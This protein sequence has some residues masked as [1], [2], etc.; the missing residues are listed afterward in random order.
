MGQ[1]LHAFVLSGC[2]QRDDKRGYQD[3]SSRSYAYSHDSDKDCR[4]D[5][6][7]KHRKYLAL[8]WRFLHVSQVLQ[9]SCSCSNDTNVD[10]SSIHVI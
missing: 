7:S 1:T 10:T 6:R 2:L 5:T 9:Q 3:N 8:G 4:C